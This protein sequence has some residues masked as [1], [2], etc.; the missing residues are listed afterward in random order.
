MVKKLL[1]IAL[2]GLLSN[3][4]QAQSAN[5]Q[6]RISEMAEKIKL[7]MG[8]LEERSAKYPKFI[9]DL[10]DGLVTIEQADSQV[11][12]LLEQLRVVTEQM[13]DQSEF[14]KTIDDYKSVI[15]KLIGEAEAS[16]I[17]AIRATVDSLQRTLAKVNEADSKRGETVIEAR[18]LIRALEVSRDALSF[19]VRAGQVQRASELLAQNVLEFSDIVA[20]GKELAGGLVSAANP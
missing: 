12:A 11:A 20:N 13:D 18:N 5:D 10:Q 14:D 1:C 7:V 3:I 15:E 2:F 17:D 6:A 9:E 16:N 19:F 8:Q 4:A